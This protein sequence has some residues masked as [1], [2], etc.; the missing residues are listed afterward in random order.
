MSRFPLLLKT[1]NTESFT[2]ITVSMKNPSSRCFRTRP[3]SRIFAAVTAAAL[4]CMP[5]LLLQNPVLADSTTV[6]DD[7]PAHEINTVGASLI[8]S[9]PTNCTGGTTNNGLTLT[10]G[11]PSS[12]GGTLPI[13]SRIDSSAGTITNKWTQQ[14]RWE[15]QPEEDQ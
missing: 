2:L 5:S 11:V 13:T 9:S 3:L 10:S 8:N 6:N 15:Q 4:T 14:L 1:I 7:V 12:T